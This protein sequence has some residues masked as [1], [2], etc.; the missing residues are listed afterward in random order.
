MEKN[1]EKRLVNKAKKGNIAAFEELIITHET[2]IYNIAYRMFKMKMLKT[3]QEIFI[4]YSEYP[5]V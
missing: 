2:R 5:Q 4:K 3:S 1:D